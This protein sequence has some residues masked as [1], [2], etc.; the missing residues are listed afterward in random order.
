MI[1]HIDSSVTGENSVSRQLTAAIV[2]R[3]READPQAGLDYRDLALDPPP[4]FAPGAATDHVDAFLAADT[5]VIG[6][7]MYNFSVP[8]QLKSWIDQILVAGRTFRYTDTGVEGL[9]GPKRVVIAVSRGG[10]YGADT[11]AAGMEH[12]ETYL[13]SVFAFIGLAPEFVVAEGVQTGPDQRTRSIDGALAAVA[14][15]AA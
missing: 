15:L 8:S 9:A 7:P 5:V 10:F 13:R 3:L 2:A 12:V 11:A 1:L 4:H 6:A 14:R